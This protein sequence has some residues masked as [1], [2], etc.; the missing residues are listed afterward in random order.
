[1]NGATWAEPR[2]KALDHSSYFDDLGRD[3]NSHSQFVAVVLASWG[4]LMPS[5]ML[6]HD[7]G[8]VPRDPIDD[9]YHKL[10][11]VR[12]DQLSVSL[13]IFSTPGTDIGGLRAQN[14]INYMIFG[15]FR[16]SRYF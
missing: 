9:E 2:S 15:R 4:V 14:V 5:Y 16:K 1:M 11:P 13:K 8:V 10:T 7:W 12:R 6:H 3:I